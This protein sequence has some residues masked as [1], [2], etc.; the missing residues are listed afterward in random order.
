MP[1]FINAKLCTK[2]AWLW[3]PSMGRKDAM[4][5]HRMLKLIY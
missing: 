1:L 4:K 3:R 2:C 5:I